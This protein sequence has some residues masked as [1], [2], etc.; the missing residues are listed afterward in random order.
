MQLE[1]KVK[2]TTY[3]TS[4]KTTFKVRDNGATVIHDDG[5]DGIQFDQGPFSISF[6]TSE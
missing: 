5:T 2:I 3:T 1:T 4:V 6:E